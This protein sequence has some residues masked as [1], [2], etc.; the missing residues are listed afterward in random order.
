MQNQ[1][2]VLMALAL[3]ASVVLGMA[4]AAEKAPTKE[5]VKPAPAAVPAKNRPGV[6]RLSEKPQRRAQRQRRQRRTRKWPLSFI[7]KRNK[8]EI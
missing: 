7:R 5:T 4:Q 1:S 2:S 3:S 8:K 6:N